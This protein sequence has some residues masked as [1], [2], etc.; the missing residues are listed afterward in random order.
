MKASIKTFQALRN[1][2]RNH[3]KDGKFV[4][5]VH[6]K[7]PFRVTFMLFSYAKGLDTTVHHGELT[8][9]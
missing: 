4:F 3:V 8:L 1:A 6:P 7:Q 9:N 5:H 2:N